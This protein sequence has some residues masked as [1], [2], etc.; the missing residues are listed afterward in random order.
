MN[1]LPYRL[2]SPL[3]GSGIESL[4]NHGPCV[5]GADLMQALGNLSLAVADVVHAGHRGIK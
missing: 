4:E 5:P 3:T 2:S 1:A